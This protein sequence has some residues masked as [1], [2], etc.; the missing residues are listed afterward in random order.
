LHDNHV[1]LYGWRDFSTFP[2]PIVHDYLGSGTHSTGIV[3]GRNGLGV[4]PGAKWMACKAFDRY[5]A[6][7]GSFL[8]C[9]QFMACPTLIDGILPDCT[10]APH[11]VYSSYLLGSGNDFYD[12]FLNLL[13]AAN[14]IPV[15]PV[16]NYLPI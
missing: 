5:G 11:V 3:V 13:H 8:A 6:L 7:F 4:A 15:F 14:I 12:D 10:K 9:L 16:G 2:S 1:G